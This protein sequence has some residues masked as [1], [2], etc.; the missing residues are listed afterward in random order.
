[1]TGGEGPGVAAPRRGS[2]AAGTPPLL[3][4]LR[5]DPRYQ[6]MLAQLNLPP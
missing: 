4:Q 3:S 5:A 1:M 6:A 2:A